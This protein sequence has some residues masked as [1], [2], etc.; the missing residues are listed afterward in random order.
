MIEE[1]I[2]YLQEQM[3]SCDNEDSYLIYEDLQKYLLKKTANLEK[4]KIAF[5]ED[6]QLIIRK[7]KWDKAPNW[8]SSPTRKRLI[9]FYEYW[10]EADRAKRPR[11]RFEKEKTWELTKRLKR[12]LT[13]EFNN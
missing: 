6:I 1:I 2:I 9:E 4:R 13:N 11:M 7:E 5:Q 10:S 8:K 12:W 3:E